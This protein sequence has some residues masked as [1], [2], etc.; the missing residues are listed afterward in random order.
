[1]KRC[2]ESYL[3]YQRGGWLGRVFKTWLAGT[4]TRRLQAI[5]IFE[6]RRENGTDDAC[7]NDQSESRIIRHLTV[8]IIVN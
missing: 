7:G 8:P 3:P 5:K 4:I 2:N 6:I 1:V